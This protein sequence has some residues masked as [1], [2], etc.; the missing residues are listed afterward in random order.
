MKEKDLYSAIIISVFVSEA[1]NDNNIM[2][3]TKLISKETSDVI[4]SVKKSI[5]IN[6]TQNLTD[7]SKNDLENILEKASK[8]FENNHP[9]LDALSDY[10]EN[11]SDLFEAGGTLVE[12]IQ[13]MAEYTQICELSVEIKHYLI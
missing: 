6:E 8:T 4:S 10:S 12:A 2:D 11:I 9:K 1:T 3:Y 5:S 7:F 13:R